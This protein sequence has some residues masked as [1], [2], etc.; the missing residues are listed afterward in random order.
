[1]RNALGQGGVIRVA[2]EDL[3]QRRAAVLDALRRGCTD[4]CLFVDLEAVALV[5]ERRRAVDG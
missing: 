2:V 3:G 5:A 1:M 4:N